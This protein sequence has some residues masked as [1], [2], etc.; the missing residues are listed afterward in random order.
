[1]V[2]KKLLG[3]NYARCV[4]KL[5]AMKNGGQHMAG[6]L[7]ENSPPARGKYKLPEAKDGFTKDIK[8]SIR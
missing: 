7:K 8:P 3:M 1:M 5:I 4:G 6:L 2:K